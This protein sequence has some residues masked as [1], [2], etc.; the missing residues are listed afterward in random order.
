LEFRISS[1]GFLLG[2]L[3]FA[4]SREQFASNFFS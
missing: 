3:L 4:P 1:F 2:Y